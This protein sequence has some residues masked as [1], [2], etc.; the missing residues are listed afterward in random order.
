MDLSKELPEAINL[1]WEDEEWIQPIDYEQLP[2]WCRK[3]HDHGH[4][5]RE[6]PKLA[7]VAASTKHRPVGAMENDGFTQ[8]RNRR[9]SKG[10]GASKAKID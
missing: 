9:R 4:L 8:V 5:G 2:F 3:C 10:G 6:F 1:N 7:P